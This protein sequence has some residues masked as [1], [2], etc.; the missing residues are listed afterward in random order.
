MFDSLLNNIII[1]S[2]ILFHFGNEACSLLV[3]C[4]N[5]REELTASYR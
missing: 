4:I 2:Y 3:A 5:E 1:M